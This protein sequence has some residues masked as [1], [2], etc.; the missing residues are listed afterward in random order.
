MH[1]LRRQ[2]RGNASFM[3]TDKTLAAI[4]KFKDGQGNYIWVPGL[5]GGIVGVLSR[6]GRR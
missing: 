1:A 5:Q 4:R 2:Y 6:R 3:M